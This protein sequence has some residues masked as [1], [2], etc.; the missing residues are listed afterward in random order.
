LKDRYGDG[1]CYVLLLINSLLK[2]GDLLRTQRKIHP[3]EIIA[4]FLLAKQFALDIFEKELQIHQ[5][6][7]LDKYSKQTIIQNLINTTLNTCSIIQ[8]TQSQSVF[9]SILATI[10]QQYTLENKLHLNISCI[11]GGDV[12]QSFAMNNSIFL[13]IHEDNLILPARHHTQT[14]NSNIPIDHRIREFF[15][16]KSFQSRVRVCLLDGPFSSQDAK[17]RRLMLEGN[18]SEQQDFSTLEQQ[19]EEAHLKFLLDNKV[20][21][22]I[23]TGAFS[24]RVRQLFMEYHVVGIMNV[25]REDLQILERF[26]DGSIV[27][28]LIGL[29]DNP[30]NSSGLLFEIE[31][32]AHLDLLH[33]TRSSNIEKLSADSILQGVQLVVSRQLF[34]L[35]SSK[36]TSFFSLVLRGGTVLEF[37]E[38]EYVLRC[39][40]RMV[41]AYL[42]SKTLVVGGCL[43][44]KWLSDA[45]EKFAEGKSG[46]SKQIILA[47][48]QA[49]LTPALIMLQNSGA[50]FPLA[51]L[52][53]LQNQCSPHFGI[54]F[55]GFEVLDFLEFGV[56][57]P[58][59]IKYNAIH[60]ACECACVLLQMDPTTNV[61]K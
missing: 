48:A 61:L 57:E 24:P 14:L 39:A 44:D 53:K 28:S 13:S 43:V 7:I 23:S 12:K 35:Q 31:F 6:Q 34:L 32:L 49:L 47:F 17:S 5:A 4:N 60:L 38:I 56:I 59:I 27:Y 46:K 9:V 51:K 1:S 3:N 41:E 50:Q 26:I 20:Q 30:H 19:R 33:E 42:G 22:I 25:S 10:F 55:A 54:D 8:Q 40:I 37:S 15:L 11:P 52:N 45:V 21:L 36:S 2:E 18:T 29:L 16:I 58:S